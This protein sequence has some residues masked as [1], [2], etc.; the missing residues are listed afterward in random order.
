[1]S[2]ET[3]LV[4]EDEPDIVELIQYWLEREG[5]LVMTASDGEKGLAEALER[6]PDMIILD[7]MLPGIDGLEV[8][9]RLRDSEATAATP[10]LMLTAR[11]EEA[12]IVVGLELGAD[13]Y[14]TKPFSP[15]QLVAR[16]RAHLRREA[17][18]ESKETGK[19]R[20][21]R[22]GVTLDAERHELHVDGKLVDLTR[23]EFRLL[24]MLFSKPGRVF[25]RS[26]LVE[27]LTGGDAFILERNVDVHVSSVRKK[28]GDSGNLIVTIRGVGYKCRD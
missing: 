6:K 19:T 23:A 18:A 24:W 8:C 7:L 2:K 26:E 12:D 13:D 4:I 27:T 3:V 5:Y 28:L 22:E 17:R 16:V 14:M 10:L 20:I 25:E 21:E 1:V 15:R 9:R 11:S